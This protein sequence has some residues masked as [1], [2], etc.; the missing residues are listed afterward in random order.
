MLPFQFFFCPALTPSSYVKLLFLIVSPKTSL[1]IA[2]PLN[3]FI[4][5]LPLFSKT[6]AMAIV[7][8]YS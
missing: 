5:L 4:S 8:S 7:S 6:K 3:A 1:K 2:S